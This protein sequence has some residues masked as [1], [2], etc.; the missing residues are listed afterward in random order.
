MGFYVFRQIVETSESLIYPE[1]MPVLSSSDQLNFQSVFLLHMELNRSFTSFGALSVLLSLI[2]GNRELK[3][4]GVGI[5]QEDLPLSR[6]FTTPMKK[7][8]LNETLPVFFFPE[9]VIDQKLLL[10]GG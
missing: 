1:C 8:S 4:W 5:Y 6:S 3:G 2:S 9:A 7:K 10:N